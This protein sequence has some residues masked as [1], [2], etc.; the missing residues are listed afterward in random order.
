M[1]AHGRKSGCKRDSGNRGK[2]LFWKREDVKRMEHRE[3]STEGNEASFQEKLLAKESENTRTENGHTW[4][5]RE[6]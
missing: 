5:R 2:A 1:E 4:E 3:V 6:S